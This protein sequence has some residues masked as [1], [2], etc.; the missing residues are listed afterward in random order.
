MRLK[1]GGVF[2]IRVDTTNKTIRP[3]GLVVAVIC[4]IRR[5]LQSVRG[6]DQ[7]LVKRK[8]KMERMRMYR[9]CARERE[10]VREK[11]TKPNEG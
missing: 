10:R 6:K 3:Q 5:Q 1:F 7:S 2:L 8:T 9:V 4:R 11:E